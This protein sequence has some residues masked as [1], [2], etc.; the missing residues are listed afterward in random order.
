MGES[1]SVDFEADFLWIDPCFVAN[2]VANIAHGMSWQDVWHT[3][4]QQSH[5]TLAWMILAGLIGVMPMLLYDWV[6]IRV[7]E[8]QGK[9]K[10]S[11]K[12]FCYLHGSRIRSITWQ[13][14]EGLSEQ[15]CAPVLWQSTRIGK[16]CWQ[17]SLRLLCFY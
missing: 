16:W 15:A 10:M 13:D 14:S 9:P 5:V 7:L 2:Q 3:M 1:T 17:Q 6:T 11:R 4:E 12:D 8:K